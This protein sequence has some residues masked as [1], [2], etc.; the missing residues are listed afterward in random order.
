[1]TNDKE[2]Q[3]I[4]EAHVSGL[5]SESVIDGQWIKGDDNFMT[6][7]PD[8]GDDWQEEFDKICN[9]VGL[10]QGVD[11]QLHYFGDDQADSVEWTS[12]KGVRQWRLGNFSEFEW[13]EDGYEVFDGG[14]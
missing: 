6:L 4:W 14:N 11:Y 5:R 12:S 3:L 8:W 13:D 10:K 2:S 9:T 7:R 1:M